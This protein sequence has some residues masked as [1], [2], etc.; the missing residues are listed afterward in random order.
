MRHTDVSDEGVRLLADAPELRL[1]QICGTK[2]TD[3]G[4][5]QLAKIKTLKMLD[6]AVST[7]PTTALRNWPVWTWNCCSCRTRR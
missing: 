4:L 7:C 1:L 2:V 3:A 6:F 5:A